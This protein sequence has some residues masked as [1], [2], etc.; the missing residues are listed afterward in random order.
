MDIFRAGVFG[1][2][3]SNGDWQ[4]GRITALHEDGVKFDLITGTSV[5]ALNG[6]AVAT[7]RVPLLL[8]LWTKLKPSMVM[9]E[10]SLLK[11]GFQEA[12]FH[13][14]LR[15]ERKSIHDSSPLR[16]LLDELFIGKRCK[17]DYFCSV[18]VIG[19]NSPNRYM[20]HH[21]P[22]GN[23]ISKTDLDMVW[24]STAIPGIFQEVSVKNMKVY[25]GGV[26]HSTPISNAIRNFPTTHI[27]AVIC[28]PLGDKWAY[29]GRGLAGRAEWVISAML[30]DQFESEWQN[31]RSW[32]SVA[33][34][35]SE[36]IPDKELIING[37]P[38][39]YIEADVHAPEKGLGDSLDFS[40]SK[41]KPNFY[42]GYNSYKA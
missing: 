38:V 23:K 5:G 25:D 19:N 20:K 36:N 9:K 29:L 16:K 14:G 12:M 10:S 31:M 6:L 40:S 24:G 39:K 2:G 30:R 11:A 4:A 41:T 18:V 7:D 1:G 32:N 13:L 3:G 33:K 27:T 37:Q 42:A 22:K 8:D 28:Q 35:W 21:I 34:Q 17:I 15:E 26:L